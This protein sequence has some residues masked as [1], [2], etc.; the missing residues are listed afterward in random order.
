MGN[1]ATAGSPKTP[2]QTQFPCKPKERK[3]E[4]EHIRFLL[5]PISIRPTLNS[6]SSWACGIGSLFHDHC[7]LEL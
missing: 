2:L 1:L 5:G 7:C 3:L 4:A 6:F